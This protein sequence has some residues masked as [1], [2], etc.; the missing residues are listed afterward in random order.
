MKHPVIAMKLHTGGVKL[1][2]SPEPIIGKMGLPDGC[3][4]ILFVFNSKKAARDYWGKNV[5]LKE[6]EALK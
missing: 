2:T 6:I 1:S 4:G 3:T 5:E